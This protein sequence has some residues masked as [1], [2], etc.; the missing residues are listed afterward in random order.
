MSYRGD[1]NCS[2]IFIEDHTPITNAKPRLVAPPEALHIAVPGSGKFRQ[3]PVDPTANIRRK[4]LP[5]ASARGSEDDRL[6]CENIAHRD[7][8]VKA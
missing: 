3:P 8:N 6:S 2:L 1:N 4:L 5:L 7:I